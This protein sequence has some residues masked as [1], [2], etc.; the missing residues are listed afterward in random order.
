[1][2]KVQKLNRIMAAYLPENKRSKKLLKNIGFNE[3]GFIPD[4]III[5]GKWEAQCL[6]YLN[7][8]NGFS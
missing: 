1:M 2:F 4:Y 3:I 6:A 5:N 8:S 7:R